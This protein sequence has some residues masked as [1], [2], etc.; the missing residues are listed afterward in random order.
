MFVVQTILTAST[1]LFTLLLKLTDLK[2][3]FAFPFC[4]LKNKVEDQRRCKE[5]YLTVRYVF[6]IMISS[7]LTGRKKRNISY[8]AAATLLKFALNC[9][10]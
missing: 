2:G 9:Y 10:N 6:L 4:S 1:F 3:L 5:R 8:L 7:F